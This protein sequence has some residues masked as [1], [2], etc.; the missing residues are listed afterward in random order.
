MKQSISQSKFY[1]LAHET[2]VSVKYR[3]KSY[4]VSSIDLEDRSIKDIILFQDDTLTETAKDSFGHMPLWVNK[5][6]LR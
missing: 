5:V 3:K 6:L 4:Y 2:A 1:Q